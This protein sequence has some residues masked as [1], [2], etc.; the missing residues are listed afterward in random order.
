M[1]K[2]CNADFDKVM[3]GQKRKYIFVNVIQAETR[4]ILGQPQVIKEIRD[5][6]YDFKPL[7]VRPVILR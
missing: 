7:P 3:L 4:G 6:H 1:A 5:R 2:R